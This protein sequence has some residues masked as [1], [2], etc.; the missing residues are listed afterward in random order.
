MLPICDLLLLAIS[1][2]IPKICDFKLRYQK[3]ILML[4][5]NNVFTSEYGKLLLE[6]AKMRPAI[7]SVLF[8]VKILFENIIWNLS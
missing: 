3:F 6:I 4:I 8:K 5:M 1:E 2:Y 7:N